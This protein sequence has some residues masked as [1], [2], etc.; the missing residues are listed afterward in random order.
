MSRTKKLKIVWQTGANDFREDSFKRLFQCPN[1]AFS[2][3]ATQ[4]GHLFLNQLSL[5]Q[6]L[7]FRQDQI[8]VHDSS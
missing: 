2:Y 7:L 5:R 1:P 8:G 6:P 3:W 4:S